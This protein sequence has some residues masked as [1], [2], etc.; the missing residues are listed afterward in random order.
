M[1]KISESL[2]IV[3]HYYERQEMTYLMY[4]R[5]TEG[6][7]NVRDACIEKL[8]FLYIAINDKSVSIYLIKTIINIRDITCCYNYDWIC[9]HLVFLISISSVLL[10][11]LEVSQ[12]IYYKLSAKLSIT[13]SSLY[14]PGQF[15]EV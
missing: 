11:S 12:F 4:K 8:F 9:W 7:W 10:F 15:F 1:L 13:D 2:T 5:D 3:I 14:I 6:R